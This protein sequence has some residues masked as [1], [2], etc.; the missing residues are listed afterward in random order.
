M[1]LE[2][3]PRCVSVWLGL[4]CGQCVER[5]WVSSSGWVAEFTPSFCD[6]ISWKQERLFAAFKYSRRYCSNGSWAWA[7]KK[8]GF[9]WTRRK[10]L[11]IQNWN[12]SRRFQ[13]FEWVVISVQWGR[14]PEWRW[15]GQCGPLIACTAV[16]RWS[17]LGQVYAAHCCLNAATRRE[18]VSFSRWLLAWQSVKQA[19][20]VCALLGNLHLLVVISPAI[21]RCGHGLRCLK[22]GRWARAVDI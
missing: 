19:L 10:F 5:L 3:R 20:V 1:R 16:K 14:T 21:C 9:V 7:F 4:V 22:V 15:L 18:D 13:L 11:Q 8:S 2:Y 6:Y 12:D 17:Q